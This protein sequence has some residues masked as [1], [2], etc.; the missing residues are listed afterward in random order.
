MANLGVSFLPSRQN[1]QDPTLTTPG[2]AVKPTISPLNTAWNVLSLRLPKF[3]GARS[4]APQELLNA[5]GAGGAA[6]ALPPSMS[7]G[8]GGSPVSGGTDSGGFNPDSALFEAAV[9]AM[10]GVGSTA[11]T[12]FGDLGTPEVPRLI[13]GVDEKGSSG[14]IITAPPIASAPPITDDGWGGMGSPSN[15]LKKKQDQYRDYGAGTISY[16]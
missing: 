7:A 16:Y 12:G 11:G 5:P 9:R 14:D 10:L 8:A 6:G 2:S 1:P 13:P 3:L 4:L 15:W